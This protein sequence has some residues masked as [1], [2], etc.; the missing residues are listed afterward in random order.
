MQ[1][2]VTRRDFIKAAGLTAGASLL[3]ACAPQT[4]EVVV[5]KT[6]EVEKKVVETQLV[7]KEVEKQVVVTATAMPTQPPAPAVMD[8][9]WNTDIADLAAL[10]DWKAEPDNEYFKKNWYWGGLAYTKYTPF[11]E[12]H[13]GVTLK[14]STH[15][16][17]WD[18]RQNQLMALAAGIIPDTTYGEAYVNEFVQLDVYNPLSQ[19][20]TTKFADGSFA[21]ATVDGKVYGLPK[22]SGADVLFIN[23]T[24]WEKAGLDR[25][26]LPTTWE[27]LVTAC[28]AINKINKDAKWGNTCYYTYGPGGDSYGQAMRILHWFNQAGAPIGDN[29]GKPNLNDPKAVDVWLFH[30]QLMWTSTEQLILQSESEGGSGKLFNDGVIVIKPGWN[31]D[32]TSVGDGNIDGTAIPFPTPPGGK[33]A[34]I[35]IGN[36]MESPF[37]AGKNPDL[38]IAL[39]EETTT[40]EDAQ[41]FL[42]NNAGIWIPALKSQLEQYETYDKLGG[43]K[44]DTAKNIVRITMKTLLDGGSGPLPGWPKNGSR[45]WSAWNTSYGNIWQKNL[46]AEDIKKE[47]DALQTTVEGLVAKSG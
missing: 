34:T 6:V 9:W 29:V 46:G 13:P 17:D 4:V 25:T 7:E 20:V 32:A 14:I 23:L 41:A 43:Y 11:V 42:A 21:G 22:S 38:A 37:K 16:W 19:D 5:Q 40:N 47:L 33:P 3:A 30:N 8:V 39:V 15:S 45:I 27:E 12:K 26:K 36:D 28:Q 1:K 10:K 44:T 18:L 31:N 35:V 2:K 24:T